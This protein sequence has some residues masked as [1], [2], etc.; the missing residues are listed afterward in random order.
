MKAYLSQLK[1][2]FL[3]ISYS[4]F[5]LGFFFFPS[6][7]SHSN[8]YYLAVVFPFLI[9]VFMKKVDLRSLFSNRTFLLIT[10]YLIYM[11]CTLFW[12]DSYEMS[13]LSKYGR[14]VFYILVFIC[15]TIHLTEVHRA[16]LQWLFVA[17]CW[18]A[19][20]VAIGNMIFY[21][22]KYPFA[23]RLW[24]YGLLYSPI[25]ASSQYGIVVIAC[26]Y[27]LQQQ[28]TV[29]TF[30]MYLAI[31]MANLSF[32]L[33]AQSRGPLLALVVTLCAWQISVWFL[34]I[35][36]KP[37][38]GN[39]LLVVLLLLTAAGV[40][41]SIMHPGFIKDALF[42]G[43][44]YRLVIW[45]GILGY[46]KEAPWLGQ[47]LTAEGRT[48]AVDGV[49]HKHSHSVYLATLFYGG[50]VGLLLMVAM[51]ASVFWQGF[52][53]LREPGD[54]A[55]LCMVLF[56]ALCMVTDGNMLIHH[57]KPFWLFFWFPVALVVASGLVDH[58]S[59]GE[60]KATREGVKV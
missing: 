32:M 43:F 10:I 9:A 29:K 41:L 1:T 37:D 33:L 17:L 44:S 58:P 45:E 3:P 28:C 6:T 23:S 60:S 54:L 14:R 49:M 11:F 12:A 27:L 59:H 13:D 25:M 40:A 42:R 22:S 46:V 2:Y 36:D 35:K 8:F 39:F 4:I 5:L 21:Y 15:V 51:M 57:P 19:A 31:L 7:K 47:G 55:Y 16:F 34:P 26:I 48:V 20:I 18:T 24:G 50:I 56:G 52:R 38:H 53:R 30:I